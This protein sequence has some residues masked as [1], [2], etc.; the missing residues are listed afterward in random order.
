M[1]NMADSAIV[2]TGAMRLA[3]TNMGV[4]TPMVL[5]DVFDYCTDSVMP[6]EFA[7]D[8][9]VAFAGNLEKSPFL[10]KLLL[11]KHDI[12]Y[13]L[14]GK[15]N[16]FDLRNNPNI[17]YCGAFIPE[18]V[19]SLKAS[20]GLVWDGD[21]LETCAGVTGNYLR[22]NSPHKLSLYIAAGIPVIVWEESA[23]A[24]FVM[25]HNIGICVK[26]LFSI[27]DVLSSVPQFQYE[28]IM[29]CVR[30]MSGKLRSGAMLKDAMN[31]LL[32]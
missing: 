18:K 6:V 14:Y 12:L 21:S 25:K 16:P 31:K 30:S 20:W 11:E 29:K 28:Q 22:Y 27:S 8:N 7:F 32:D 1:L 17:E 13:R 5:L 2:H 23:V 24:D 3:L 9:T 26:D 10:K 19:D 15:N 4:K